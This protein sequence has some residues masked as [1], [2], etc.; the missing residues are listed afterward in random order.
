VVTAA[1]LARQR[2]A[3]P[4]SYA[5]IAI[6]VV[7]F[8]V[9]EFDPALGRRM[10]VEGAQHP[11]LISAGEWWRALTA[12][13]LHGNFTHLL[14][15]MWALFLFGPALERRFGFASL[16]LA[17]G[18][19]GSALYHLIGRQLP[20]VGA[21]GAIFGLMGALLVATYR[22]RNTPAGRSVFSQLLLLLAINLALPLFVPS[23]AWE[24]HVGG[25][26]AGALV[27]GAWDR[28]PEAGSGLVGRRISI[29]A[30]IAVL[31]MAAILLI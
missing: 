27:V 10:F 18:I 21:S 30:A 2:A 15:N 9:G 17:S 12:I 6:N 3:A 24:A 5:L 29:S 1:Q 11:G 22:L 13:F 23:V 7:I 19:G 16:Y 31:G 20:A 4:V 8:L 28:L 14:F 26:A 25:L